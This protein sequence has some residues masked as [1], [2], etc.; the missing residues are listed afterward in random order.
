MK[1]TSIPQ[2]ARNVVRLREIVTILSKYGLADWISQLDL[3]FAKGLFTGPAGT[4]LA[5]LTRESRIRLALTELGP[6]FIKLGQMLS[7]RADLIGNKLADELTALH[8]NAP[9]D[10]SEIVREIIERELGQ[11]VEDLFAE[12]DDTPLA[13]AS[14]GQ[15]HRAVLRS[16]DVVV[17]KVQHAGI[18]EKIR[19]DLEILV[20]L[21]ELAEKQFAE[22][23]NYRPRAT[24]AELQRTLRRELDFGREERNARQFI[25]NFAD[26]PGVKIP[27]PIAELTTSRVLTMELLPGIQLSNLA[28]LREA[29]LDLGQIARRG[30]EIFLRMIFEHGFYHAD[31]HPGNLFVLPGGVIGLIDCGMVGRIDERT[32]DQIEDLLLSIAGRDGAE[33]TSIITRIGQVPPNL[34]HSGL[35]YDVNDFVAHYAEQPLENLKLGNALQEMTEIIRRYQIV[36]PAGIALLLKVLIMLEGTGRLLHPGFN[37]IELIQPYQRKLMMRRFSPLRRVKKL[38]R[39]IGEWERLGEILPKGITEIVGQIQAG[40]FEIHLHHR[41]LEP[42]VNRLVFGLLTSAMFLGSAIM[43]S[44]KVPPVVQEISLAGAAGIGASLILG[45]RLIRAI[46][47]SGHL[48]ERQ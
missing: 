31:P 29:R 18:E 45:M 4:Q 20:G 23:R 24:T 33:L 8:S 21:A 25:S 26:D 1:L 7:T 42:S 28:C 19:D 30:A 40:R 44:T 12:F 16:G 35:D 32:R 39:L 6:T 15:V 2:L 37:L 5:Q 46:N 43:L 9:A 11:T 22:L 34:D 13:S 47:K 48:D 17:V 27:A 10:P 38:G 41:S 36:L 14:I 3:D